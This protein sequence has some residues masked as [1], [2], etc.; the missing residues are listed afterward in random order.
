MTNHQLQFTLQVPHEHP[1]FAGHFEGNPIVPGAVLL[2]WFEREL[3]QRQ[4]AAIKTIKQVKFY[5][6]VPPGSALNCTVTQQGPAIKFSATH[7]S[8]Q[9]FSG[10]AEL[11]T[12]EPSGE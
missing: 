12:E 3:L 7:N 4:L 5:T 9:V 10:S 1:C 2:T 11:F 8:E 6:P